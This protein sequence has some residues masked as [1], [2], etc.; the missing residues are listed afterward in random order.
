MWPDV[1]GLAI[2]DEGTQENDPRVD[3]KGWRHTMIEVG[4]FG[5]TGYMGGEVIPPF[6]V[7]S[8]RRPLIGPG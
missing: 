1:A 2:T 3:D 6:P 4:I 8:R 5:G 7:W